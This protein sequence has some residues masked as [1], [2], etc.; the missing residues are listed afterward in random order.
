MNLNQNLHPL[1]RYTQIGDLAVRVRRLLQRWLWLAAVVLVLET[2]L[3]FFA[4]ARG[5]MAFGAI[6]AG[7]LLILAV[8]RGS[9]VGLPI[10]PI[11]AIQ[12]LIA[13]GLPIVI[14]HEITR[15][16][17]PA[18]LT[19]AGLEVLIFSVALAA[20]WLFGMKIFQ[21]APARS[22]AL[23]GFNRQGSAKLR[24]LG[25]SLIIGATAYQALQG[26][27]LFDPILSRLPSGTFSLLV[28]LSGAAGACGFFLVSMFI[29]ARSLP[30]PARTLFW[31]L[32][33]GN[34][35][36]S[37]SGYLLSPATATVASV[38]IGLFW[39]SGRV[40]WR[41]LAVV[42]FVLSFLNIGKYTMRDRYWKL[43]EDESRPTLTLAEMPASYAEWFGVS[44]D[45]FMGRNERTGT[46]GGEKA[47]SKGLSLLERIN[48]LQNLLYVIDAMETWSLP[49]LGGKTYALIPPLLLPRIL[50]PNKPRSHE[51]QVMLNVHFGRQDLNSTFTTY[52]AWGLL[53]EAYGN[54][55]SK[56]GAI[57]IGV[58]MGV[59]FAWLE[60]FTARKLL[61]SLEGFIA[62][63]ILLVMASSFEMVASVLVTSLFQAI[64]TL[65]L[66]SAAFI[67][68]TTLERP[69]AD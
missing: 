28:A 35:L 64:V 29:G 13:Y 41:Y 7:T 17:S 25:F 49:P 46:L 10:V 21:L 20:A 34:C 52:V 38:L 42:V 11:L 63:I 62:F 8:W 37:A 12:H 57:F 47:H 32:L 16:Y 33:V 40:P 3:L 9:G 6:A 1:D 59:F 56:S 15:T 50:W 60:K 36:I 44:W 5:A 43:G 53:P 61:L 4:E 30:G 23:R 58:C 39:S 2:A 18:Y 24:R 67:E 54:F 65:V 14:K 51:G 45:I 22:Y 68:R 19:K 66:A 26:T 27:S 55:G 31:L 48:N 69:P